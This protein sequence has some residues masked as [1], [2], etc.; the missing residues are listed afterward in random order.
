MCNYDVPSCPTAS[1]PAGSGENSDLYQTVKRRDITVKHAGPPTETN[2]RFTGMSSG[3]EESR[4]PGPSTAHFSIV[5]EDDSDWMISKNWRLGKGTV[6]AGRKNPGGNEY[7]GGVTARRKAVTVQ[8]AVGDARSGLGEAFGSE[9]RKGSDK[10]W[11]VRMMV[12]LV[13]G[14]LVG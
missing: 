4:S 6:N 1:A 12:A 13:R 3:P 9:G 14:P 7:A 2:S 10:V 8:M 5:C 11:L